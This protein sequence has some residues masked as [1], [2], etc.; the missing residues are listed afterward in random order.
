MF[1]IKKPFP[2][3]KT[4]VLISEKKS[5]ARVDISHQSQGGSLFTEDTCNIGVCIGSGLQSLDI[6]SDLN[7]SLNFPG[8]WDKLHPNQI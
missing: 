4:K 6:K 5:S 7:I 2:K 1:N 3:T 8:I